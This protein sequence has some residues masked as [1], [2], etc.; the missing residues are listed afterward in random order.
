MPVQQLAL[1]S[2]QISYGDDGAGPPVIC[3]HSGGLTSRQWRRLREQLAPKY[4]VLTP[5]LIGYAASSKWPAGEPFHFERDVEVVLALARLVDEPLHFVGH[6]YGG[7][8]ACHAARVVPV[9]S[10]ALYEPV[11]YGVLDRERDASELAALNLDVR[12]TPDASGVD[13]AW[14]SGFVDWWNGP[15]SWAR[16]PAESAAAFRSVGEKLFYEVQTLGADTTSTEFAAITA[17]TLVM[18]GSL[19]HPTE[20]RAVQRLTEVLPNST[21]RR[22]DG[23]GHMGPITHYKLI[24]GAIVEHIAKY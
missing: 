24:D 9:R 6:S 14:L 12:W 20:Q 21:L 18:F 17:P 2:L 16:L 19:T 11:T 5:D 22:F 1:G 13:E 23:L 7:F 10:M 8:L 4:R 15:G 3:L